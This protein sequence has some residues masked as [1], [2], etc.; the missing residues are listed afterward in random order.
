MCVLLF[1][2]LLVMLLPLHLWQCGFWSAWN[3]EPSS[4]QLCARTGL[5]GESTATNV[6][7]QMTS[8]PLQPGRR[9]PVVV[10]DRTF[11]TPCWRDWLRPNLTAFLKLKVSPSVCQCGLTE[12]CPCSWLILDSWCPVG[13]NIRVGVKH[14]S[15]D[16]I[17]YDAHSLMLAEH[18]EKMNELVRQKFWFHCSRWTVSCWIPSE[19]FV[20]SI[21]SEETINIRQ[22]RTVPQ[23]CTCCTISKETV[24][25]RQ[26]RT[27]PQWSTCCTISKET[28]NIR[29]VRTVP[30]WCTCGTVSEETINIRQVRTVVYMWYLWY[31][32]VHVVPMVQWCTCTYGTVVYM[33]YL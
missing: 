9:W 28:I 16:R 20:D 19:V 24:N 18:W 29:Q 1:S 14:K 26:V 33:W 25:I 8:L 10:M 11:R 5:Q 22:V 32:G 21:V 4:P 17:V 31:S 6:S 12:W 3:I 13:C 30:Q 23:W 2:V 15:L 27:V 7:A